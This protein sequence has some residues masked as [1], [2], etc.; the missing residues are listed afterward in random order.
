MAYPFDD[1]FKPKPKKSS[2][3]SV[4][5]G[6]V[7]QQRDKEF[8]AFNNMLQTSE[9]EKKEFERK[10]TE[11]RAEENLKDNITNMQRDASKL[12]NY[13]FGSMEKR[14]LEADISFRKRE[15]ERTS[16]YH[17]EQQKKRRDEFYDHLRGK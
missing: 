15:L 11:F 1:D 14:R 4:D 6:P 5:Y 10:Y 7:V 2:T 8:K 17:R 16:S 13:G 3:F 9:F 12:S